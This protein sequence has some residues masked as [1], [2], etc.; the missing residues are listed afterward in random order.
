MKIVGFATPA[1]SFVFSLLIF[2]IEEV[3]VEI[4]D[5]FGRKN[6]LQDY[7]RNAPD[8]YVDLEKVINQIDEDC[9]RLVQTRIRRPIRY[10]GDCNA[11]D[12]SLSARK[13]VRAYTVHSTPTLNLVRLIL[14]PTTVFQ[15][16]ELRILQSSKPVS[17]EN[18]VCEDSEIGEADLHRVERKA[19]LQSNEASLMG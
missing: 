12:H 9:A 6:T 16:S 11:F 17:T 14:C 19:S 8:H 4:E 15:N 10:V 5:P 13:H 2:S 1:V 3:A 7:N 18:S